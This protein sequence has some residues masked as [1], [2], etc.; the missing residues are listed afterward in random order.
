PGADAP[1]CAGARCRFQRRGISGKDRSF[2]AGRGEDIPIGEPLQ[3]FSANA[4]ESRENCEPVGAGLVSDDQGARHVSPR[5][6]AGATIL[7]IVPA[8]REEPVARTAVAVA[9]ALLQSGARALVAAEAGPLADELR[10][11]GGEWVPLANDTNNPLR[12]RSCG[13]TLERLI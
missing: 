7:Q 8:L 4:S 12:L 13:H 10:A 2:R 9:H 1:R 5:T 6:L 3:C 11:G